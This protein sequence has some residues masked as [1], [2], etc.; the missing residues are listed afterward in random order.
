LRRADYWIALHW[1]LIRDGAFS[2]AYKV[3]DLAAWSLLN[4]ASVKKLNDTRGTIRL[5]QALTTLGDIGKARQLLS[6]QLATSAQG[7]AAAAA[8]VSKVLADLDFLEGDASSIVRW[9]KSGQTSG[10]EQDEAHE[11]ARKVF[12]D[13]RV[14][15]I[16]PGR[17]AE[18]VSDDR[19]D[20][21][22]V[23]VRPNLFLDEATARATGS[24]RT[25]VA[26]FNSG[27]TRLGLE[28]LLSVAGDQ[29]LR[30]VVLRRPRATCAPPP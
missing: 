23:V 19:F 30:Q 6:L 14:A 26:Y 22:D 12:A 25:D 18:N 2:A 3:K 7:D 9:A 24:R 1:R 20:S 13:R 21:Y 4:N 27:F 17:P 5:A 29:A 16:G 11:T 10:F 15:I 8:S 28:S